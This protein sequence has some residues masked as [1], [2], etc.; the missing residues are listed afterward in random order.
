M[1]IASSA[2]SMSGASSACKSYSREESLKFWVGDR[3]PDFEGREQPQ[4]L[5]DLEQDMLDLSEQ[6]KAM[7]AQVKC[8]VEEVRAGDP[9]EFEI[10]DQDKLKILLIETMIEALT[11]KKFKIRVLD[12]LDLSDKSDLDAD[13]MEDQISFV[14]PGSGFLALDLNGDGRINDGRELFG[15]ETGDG[16]AELARYD[17]DGNQWIDENDPV[18]E[19]LRIWTKDAEG[20]DVLRPSGKRESAPSISATWPR[21]LP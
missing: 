18:F 1:K 6:A 10:S 20:R 12:K 5:T 19:R 15:P 3:R 8:P 17:E 9:A 11:G 21:P 14:L 4:F 2:V 16:F 13:G 7:L